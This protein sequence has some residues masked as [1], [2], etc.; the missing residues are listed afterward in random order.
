MPYSWYR[1]FYPNLQKKQSCYTLFHMQIEYEATFT[2]IDKE[3]MRQTLTEVGATL[4]REEYLQR[5]TV[6]NPPKGNEIEGG[7][8][9]VRD[10]GDKVT[11]S[12]KVVDGD[13]IENQ[14][15]ICVTVDDYDEAEKLL[16][17]VGCQW[18]AY[19]ET[20]RELWTLDSVEITIDTWPF[21]EP[22]VEVEGETEELVKAVS[23]KLGFDWST[24][25]FCSV[26]TL[27]SEKYGLSIDIVNNE[28]PKI[29][30]D[31]ENPFLRK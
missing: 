24:A 15:E 26:D 19:Q 25:K 8:Q 20:R 28:T 14:K 2:N 11:M 7:W 30:F 10:E 3:V 4:E 17:T 9:R 13:Q 12:L 1:T 27:Y 23:E 18:C 5:R 29:V 21:L 31:M 22:F 16:S 6:F